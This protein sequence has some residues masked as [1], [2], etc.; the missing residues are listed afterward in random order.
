[1]PIHIPKPLDAIWRLLR[2]FT[3]HAARTPP[4][5][6]SGPK[7]VEL[8]TPADWVRHR[9]PK[10]HRDD[11]VSDATHKW[12]QR[13][14]PEFRPYRLCAAFPRIANRLAELWRDPGLTDH[15]LDELLHSRREG[16]QGFPPAVSAELHTLSLGNEQRLYG[17]AEPPTPEPDSP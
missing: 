9:V 8:M 10:R 12:V 3:F 4:P 17:S 15:Y 13:L 16:R 1:M 5:A 11:A 2:R 7:P 6:P 14:P